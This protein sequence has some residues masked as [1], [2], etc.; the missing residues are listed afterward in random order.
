M[1]V[2]F[3]GTYQGNF[4]S[5]GADQFIPLPSGVDWMQVY[6]Q[7]VIAN[8]GANL[9]AQF[10]W[11]RGMPVSRGIVYI[12]TAATNAMDPEL[13]VAGDGFIYY[14]TSVNTLG[15]LTATTAI[16]NALPPVVASAG[17]DVA[18]GDIVRLYSPIGALQLGGIDFTVGA[19]NSG[20]SFT[21]ANMAAIANA[22]AAGNYRRIPFNPYFYP[23]S[24]YITK[25]ASVGAAALVTLSV[26]HNYVVGQAVRFVVPTVTA[27]AF[28]MTQLDGLQGT[29]LAVGVTDG[30][31]TNT[32]VV[33]IDVSGFTA[34]AWPLTANPRCTPPQVIPVGDN[35]AVSLIAGADI[36]SDA[37]I[38]TAQ[39]GMLLKPGLLSPAGTAADG[40]FWVAGKSV[41]V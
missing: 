40:I 10:Y 19:V 8:V 4:I 26:T 24:R 3:T 25:V 32:I 22:P 18:N 11:Q 6:N 38:N 12:K 16:S 33:D 30:T 15:A 37:T 1:S 23:S 9:G 41:N 2:V 31:S 39:T 7:T 17:T 13:I 20:V 5:T 35:T 21:L 14:D 36:L 28:G 27:V 29:I 34:F